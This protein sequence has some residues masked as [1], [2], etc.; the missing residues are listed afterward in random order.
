MSSITPPKSN[1]FKALLTKPVIS[2]IEF[3]GEKIQIRKLTVSEVLKT[4][5]LIKAVENEEDSGFKILVHLVKTAVPDAKD[6]AEEDFKSLP[7]DELS[8]LSNQI[9]K[10]SGMIEEKKNEGN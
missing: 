6:I 8:K 10:F 4:Q 5:Q 1:G 9:M 3:L 2:E 7:M